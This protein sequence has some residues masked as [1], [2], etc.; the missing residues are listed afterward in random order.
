[1]S[2]P[3]S[4]PSPSTGAVSEHPGERD[5]S[6]GR[7][8]ITTSDV[9]EACAAGGALFRAHVLTPAGRGAPFRATLRSARIGA[10]TLSR[11]QYGAGVR[12]AAAP[13]GGVLV[14]VP[15]RGVLSGRCGG[16][17]VRAAAGTAAVIDA[18]R[19]VDMTWSAGADLLIVGVEAGGLERH[20]AERSG[21]ADRRAVTPAFDL[22]M[23]L[24]TVPA[25][26]WWNVVRFVAEESAEGPGPLSAEDRIEALVIE[27]L[28]LAQQHRLDIARRPPPAVRAAI[29]YMAEHAD[30]PLTVAEIAAAAHVSVRSLQSS[31]A[32]VMGCSPMAHLRGIRL[33]RLH[34]ELAAA[35]AE[36]T[37]VTRIAARWQLFHVGR[38]AASY[39]ER[40]GEPPSATLRR[41]PFSR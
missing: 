18:A 39:R 5:L 38:L 37:G 34:T 10:V 32:A 16:E 36:D 2:M 12:I 15:L 23:D 41:E 14:H 7:E 22:R 9:E 35:S 29:A 24:A 33:D 28:L 20:L 4:T 8:V 26:A 27:R 11:V 1:M 3:V 25:R 17:P 40:F 13:T 19:D 6:V 30:S 31:F 21:R